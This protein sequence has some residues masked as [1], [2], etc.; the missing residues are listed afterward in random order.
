M[1]ASK[2]LASE[3]LGGAAIITAVLLMLTRTIPV[4][5]SG[6]ISAQEFPPGTITGTVNLA[7]AARRGWELS[8]LMLL[9]ALA[10]FL[11]GYLVLYAE[12]KRRGQ[13]NFALLFIVTLGAGLSAY[14]IAGV[15]DGFLVSAAANRSGLMSELS[16]DSTAAFVA[17]AHEAALSLFGLAQTGIVLGIGLAC[18]ALLR[19]GLLNRWLAITGAAMSDLALIGLAFGVYGDYWRNLE[20]AGPTMLLFQLWQLALGIAML[21]HKPMA[22]VES[23]SHMHESPA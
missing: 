17:F 20:T 6:A 5:A 4:F 14:A 16:A 3:K 9:A 23:R 11:I 18:G 19:A 2:K 1:L 7:I 12:L 22:A 13:K 8:H 10:L 21:R 15:T